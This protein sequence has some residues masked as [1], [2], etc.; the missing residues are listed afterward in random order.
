MQDDFLLL[1]KLEIYHFVPPALLKDINVDNLQVDEFLLYLAMA[2]QIQ[3]F[4]TNLHAEAIANA[5][6]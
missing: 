2:R 3:K 4:E 1:G 5:I 6:K